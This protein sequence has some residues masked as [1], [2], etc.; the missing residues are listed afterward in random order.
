MGGVWANQVEIP[1]LRGKPQRFYRPE[2]DCLR[3]FAF[4]GVFVFHTF[5][6][7]PSY[8]VKRHVPF[9]YAIA[10]AARAGSFGVDLFFLLSAYLITE[11]LL[12]EKEQ[13]GTI[14]LKSFYLRRILRIWPLYF[15]ALLIAVVLPLIDREQHFG[16][17][18]LLAFLLL[19]GN[20]LTSLVGFPGS[21]M[22][23]LWSVNF[24]EQFYLLWPTI[25]SR[26]RRTET[27]KL[28]SVALIVLAQAGR[29]ILLRFAR[30]SDVTIFTNTIARLDPLALGILTAV[31]TRRRQWSPGCYSRL[32]FLTG[33]GMVWL[34]AG[35]Y[36]SRTRAFMVLGYPAMALGAWL[37]FISVLGLSIAPVWLRYLGKISYGLYVW[38]M[39]GLHIAIKLLGGY[40]H[41]LGSFV[42]YWVLGLAF[43]LTTAVLSYRFFESRFLRLKERFAFVKSRPV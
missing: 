42:R 31:L 8:Y 33:G 3:F 24:E 41:E 28:V 12:R 25:V 15:F 35:Y 6:Y 38:H 23:P 43:T 34:I 19:S 14:H 36:F 10:S 7:D 32:I 4:F 29:L 16:W 2:L 39:L 40:P 9:P 5:S 1:H 26:V 17:K 21:A 27:L 13:F 18:Y 30:H 20:W 37:I 22:D 11:L